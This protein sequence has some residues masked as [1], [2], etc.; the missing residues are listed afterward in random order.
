MRLGKAMRGP[1]MAG[2]IMLLF[3]GAAP[4]RDAARLSTKLDVAYLSKDIWRGTVVYPDPVVQPSLTLALPDGFSYNLWM[5]AN[6][7]SDTTA[8]AANLVVEND[9]TLNYAFTAGKVGVNVGYVYYAF[10]HTTLAGTSE[11]YGNAC[12]GGKFSP[13]VSVN[14]DID[15]VRGA[16]FA[17]SSGCNRSLSLGKDSLPIGLSAKVGFGTASYVKRAYPGAPDK[18]ALLDLV[19]GV[20]G[21]V[22]LGGHYS[23]TPSVSYSTILDKQVSDVLAPSNFVAGV[24]VSSSF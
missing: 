3:A 21:A 23:L 4:A 15:E 6:T 20:S 18:A 17:F 12:L 22:P 19:L 11:F 1:A 13:T 14:C 24:T 16:Y 9:H 8:G 5:S 10:P 2:C 7:K